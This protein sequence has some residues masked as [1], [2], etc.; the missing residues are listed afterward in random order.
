[1][2]SVQMLVG[3]QPVDVRT[4]TETG[5]PP[6]LDPAL[7]SL[8]PMPGILVGTPGAAPPGPITVI[9]LRSGDI[10]HGT[11]NTDGSFNIALPGTPDGFYQVVSG[12]V[13][14]LNEARI[15]AV[16]YPESVITVGDGSPEETLAA[17][18]LTCYA[19]SLHAEAVIQDALIARP[20]ECNSD[21]DCIL[22]NIETECAKNC[23]TY[24]TNLQGQDYVEALEQK[25]AQEICPAHTVGTCFTEHL[26]CPDVES[27]V[28]GISNNL[29]PR[30]RFNH[31]TRQDPAQLESWG[32]PT[33]ALTWSRHDA[34]GAAPYVYTYMGMSYGGVDRVDSNGNRC[35]PARGTNIEVGSDTDIGLRQAINHDDVAQAIHPTGDAPV[36]IGNPAGSTQHDVTVRIKLNTLGLPKP[37]DLEVHSCPTCDVPVG[38]EILLTRLKDIE[39]MGFVC[40]D[41]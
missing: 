25:L 24:A 8:Q 18:G 2:L 26:A 35:L 4:G 17:L 21:A 1:M 11:A 10:Y 28:G 41:E 6:A 19:E 38:F 13:S 9:D 27:D 33:V 3:C 32:G 12:A 34:A 22:F 15:R 30:C 14:D 40:D 39:D 23:G 20:R 31:C 7:I 37:A 16:Q 36:V 29:V 5:N